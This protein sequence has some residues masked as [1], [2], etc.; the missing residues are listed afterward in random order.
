MKKRVLIFCDSYLPGYKG[1][2]GMWA[3]Y[4]LADRLRDKFDFFI[5]TRDCDGKLDQTPFVAAARDVW[6]VRPEAKVF[7]ASPARLNRQTF[8]TLIREIDP[9]VIYLNSVFSYVCTK[10]LFTRRRSERTSIPV[11]IAP[12]GEFAAAALNIK[13]AKKRS[14]LA[15]ARLSKLFGDVY[16]KASSPS[17]REEIEAV[18]ETENRIF[19]VPELAPRVLLEDFSVEQK[20]AKNPGAVRLIYFS[21]ITPKKNLH[22]LLEILKEIKTGDI[23]LDIVGPA[24]DQAYLDRCRQTASELPSNIT[25][26]FRGGVKF[27]TGL[28]ALMQSHFM[29]LPTLNENFGYVIIEAFAAGCPVIASDQIGWKAIETAGIGMRIPLSNTGLWTTQI[30]H[31]LSMDNAVFRTAAFSARDFAVE[32]LSSDKSVSACEGMFRNAIE[33]QFNA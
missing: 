11:I 10:F 14:F 16:W 27:E 7:Y 9:D 26:N 6:N 1:G 12:C 33:R 15:F 3:V 20:P 21:R 23:W 8:E 29:V 25:V 4:N 19:E 18:V 13:A 5:I 30:E 2:G 31:C 32:W 24:D 22:F 28:N 17:E